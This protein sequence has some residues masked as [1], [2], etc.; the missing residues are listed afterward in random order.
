MAPATFNN[1]VPNYK[2][3]ATL[4][5]LFGVENEAS[6][7]KQ[8]VIL[9]QQVVATLTSK[10]ESLTEKEMK[11]IDNLV[12]TTFVSKFNET[13]SEGLL[14]EQK[15]LLNR[16]ILSFSDNGV[17]VKIFLNEEKQK[18]LIFLF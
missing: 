11:P 17:D 7:I 8:G 1:F 6:S 14:H 2:S 16:Y 4:S 10:N 3:I 15:E 5:Q 9:E 12:F 13:Y 18:I